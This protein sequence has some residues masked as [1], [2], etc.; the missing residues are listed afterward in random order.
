MKEFQNNIIFVKVCEICHEKQNKQNQ[1]K[2]L[3]ASKLK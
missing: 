2:K 1:K 3:E